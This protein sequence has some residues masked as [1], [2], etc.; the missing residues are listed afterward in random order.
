MARVD[1]RPKVR[2][3]FLKRN[4]QSGSVLEPV[5]ADWPSMSAGHKNAWAQNVARRVHSGATFK[6]W[7]MA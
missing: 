6:K 2:I 7:E 5:P 4:G 3:T 1:D